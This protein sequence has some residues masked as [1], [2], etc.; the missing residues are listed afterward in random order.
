M[1]EFEDIQKLIKLKRHEKPPE[2]YFEN[3]V[4]EFHDR[5]RSELLKSS[6]RSLVVE[7]VST[8]FSGF[9]K[10]RLMYAAG[11]A[12]AA[13]IAVFSMIPKHSEPV[14]TG[15]GSGYTQVSVS[16]LMDDRNFDLLDN[17]DERALPR[18][19]DVDTMRVMRDGRASAAGSI[20]RDPA[21]EKEQPELFDREVR[22]IE[23]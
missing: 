19:D 20:S 18:M 22:I 11:G 13:A 1:S 15:G 8:Y 16:P 21:K 2:G 14:P 17:P 9:E 12:A 5:Q 3:F 7:R 6:A 23:F 10:S 4:E